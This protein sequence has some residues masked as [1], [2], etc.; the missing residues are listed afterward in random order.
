MFNCR[1]MR[2]M[3]RKCY[4]RDYFLQSFNTY[5]CF[6]LTF[7]KVSMTAKIMVYEQYRN[8]LEESMSNNPKITCYEKWKMMTGSLCNYLTVAYDSYNSNEA[9]ASEFRCNSLLNKMAFIQ[10]KSSVLENHSFWKRSHFLQFLA[11]W[12][13]SVNICISPGA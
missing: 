7:Y 13:Y 8:G 5:T 9:N 1:K 2:K 6:L 4:S 3:N 12:K 11:H 10:R